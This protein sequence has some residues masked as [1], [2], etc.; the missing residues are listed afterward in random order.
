MLLMDR[1]SNLYPQA[2]TSS[3]SFL[4]LIHHQVISRSHL[5]PI[6]LSP[7]HSNH[8]LTLVNRSKGVS[9]ISSN[10]KRLSSD[11]MI[12]RKK[13]FTKLHLIK[14]KAW[15]ALDN[16]WNPSIVILHLI[17]SRDIR[18]GRPWPPTF[19]Q[20]WWIKSW[21]LTRLGMRFLIVWCVTRK[22]QDY[23]DILD[24]RVGQTLKLNVITLDL[25]IEPWSINLARMDP[26]LILNN[27]PDGLSSISK[28]LGL[29]I[30]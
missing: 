6:K 20:V 3:V 24:S 10:H 25:R 15:Y 21:A 22:L 4:H 2:F 29:R 19:A 17:L 9:S 16:I 8:L 13:A 5:D 18:L 23:Q 30:V 28:D 14:L 27:I 26:C 11:P 7:L 1:A 12:L